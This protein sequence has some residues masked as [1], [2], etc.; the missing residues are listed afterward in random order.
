MTEENEFFDTLKLVDR[1]RAERDQIYLR[2]CKMD[3]MRN[4]ADDWKEWILQETRDLFIVIERI[5]SL[6]NPVW[7]Q[8]VDRLETRVREIQTTYS[9]RVISP[10]KTYS[11]GRSSSRDEAEH[12]QKFRFA[13]EKA[14]C[15]VLELKNMRTTLESIVHGIIGSYVGSD[16]EVETPY[17]R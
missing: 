13:M 6:G 1:R 10:M 8:A 9:R 14:E 7:T 15:L 12:F 5:K 2:K 11:R 16:E 4:F 3:A 17:I